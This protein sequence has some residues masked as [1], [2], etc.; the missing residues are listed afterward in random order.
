MN[1]QSFENNLT[2]LARQ[3]PLEATV[4]ADARAHT[5]ACASCALRLEE[6][7]SLT[8]GLRGLAQEMKEFQAPSHVESRLMEAFREGGFQRQPRRATMRPW[9][10]VAAIAAM[11]LVTVGVVA[12]RSTWTP[13]PL[14]VAVVTGDDKAVKATATDVAPINP[15]SSLEALSGPERTSDQTPRKTA[16]HRVKRIPSRISTPV[17]TAPANSTTAAAE[18]TTGFM[19]LGDVSVANLQEAAQVVRVEMPRY[20]MARFGFPVNME[21]YDEKVKADVWLGA[22]GLARAIRFVQ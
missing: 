3:H 1:C 21:R 15:I 9:F 18:V 5:Q 13:S 12:V 22:D 14:P 4:L 19:P 20:A 6:Q 17:N 11:L 7:G 10:A 8:A 16:K 2:D